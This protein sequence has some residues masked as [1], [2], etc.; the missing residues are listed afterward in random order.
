MLNEWQIE[1]DDVHDI[2]D[3]QSTGADTSGDQDWILS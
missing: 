2:L 1:V 3:I